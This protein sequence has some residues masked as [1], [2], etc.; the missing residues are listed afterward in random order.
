MNHLFLKPYNNNKKK[1]LNNRSFQLIHNLNVITLARS[2]KGD[3]PVTQ[4]I[5]SLKEGI[6][7][8]FLFF[9]LGGGGEEGSYISP[10]P[11]FCFFETA[12]R[13]RFLLK[14]GTTLAH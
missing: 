8:F 14:T 4:A 5:R 10:T 3:T 9:V 11:I 7:V 12:D 6:F 1:A 13:F 2:Y